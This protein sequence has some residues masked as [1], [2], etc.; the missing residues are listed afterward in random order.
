MSF[1]ESVKY[2][3]ASFPARKN[4]GEYAPPLAHRKR[5]LAP[6]RARE[7]VRLA[8]SCPGPEPIAVMPVA[9]KPR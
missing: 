4:V 7:T 2:E 3:G 6:G 8:A 9:H 1:D 5:V